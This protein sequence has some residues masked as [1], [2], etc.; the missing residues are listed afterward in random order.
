MSTYDFILDNIT[1]SYSSTSSFN[2]CPYGYKLTYIDSVPREDNF[3]SD[4]GTLIHDCL[5]K[6]FTE[7]LDAFQLSQYYREN[8]DL[9][10]KS[11]PPFGPPGILEKYREQG[12]AFFDFFVFE[13][14][15]YDVV[16]V[17]DN[18]KFE[19][20]GMRLIARPD[21]VLREKTTGKTI[22][23]DYKTATPFWQDK[24][25]GKEKSDK[26]RLEGYNQQMSV[27]TYALR[28]VRN[29]PIDEISLW[30]VRLNRI[31]SVPWKKETEDSTISYLKETIE[32]I[33]KEEI[34][35]YNNS[36]PYFCDNLCSVRSFC[37]FR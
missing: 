28:T 37:E 21:L 1:F 26:K 3:Y 5:E 19:V 8:Y 15:N 30:F 13:K 10:V 20:D 17:E 22:L 33:K 14:D 29:L 9:A 23:Y 16:L 11:Q 24:K 32:K 18:I 36:N 35:P 27:Y 7:K 2:N 31:V 6:Y 25:T 4:F 34:F 12:Q